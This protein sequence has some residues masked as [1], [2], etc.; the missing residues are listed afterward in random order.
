MQII[1]DESEVRYWCRRYF[2]YKKY[3]IDQQQR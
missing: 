3:T 2:V 1:F